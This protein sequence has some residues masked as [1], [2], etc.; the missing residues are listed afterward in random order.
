[1]ITAF[2]TQYLFVLERGKWYADEEAVEEEE[3]TV[4]LSFPFSG[5]TGEGRDAS[6][7]SGSSGISNER[8]DQNK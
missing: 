3:E 7:T 4:L 6:R 8:A 5:T 1:M 2:I